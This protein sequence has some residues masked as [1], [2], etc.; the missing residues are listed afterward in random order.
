MPTSSLFRHTL[1]RVVVALLAF[2]VLV[3]I[4]A[5]W[6]L[7]LP[8]LRAHA[9]RVAVDVQATLNEGAPLAQGFVR[10]VQP[11][12]DGGPSLLPFNL[13]F[14][15]ELQA[16]L[17]LPVA[18]RVVQDQP[19]HY[20]FTPG[21]RG[22]L[23]SPQ[24]WSFDQTVVVG[25]WPTE[26][27]MAW[28][29]AALLSGLLVSLWLAS[30]LTRPILQLRAQLRSLPNPV[31]SSAIKPVEIGV[32]LAELEAL[33]QDYLALH[34]RISQSLE[35]RTTL[36]LGLAH[37]LSAPVSRLTM[38]VELQAGCA[39]STRQAAMARDLTE[40]R[41][42]IEQFLG[43]AGCLGSGARQA[44]S[45][46]ELLTWLNRHYKTVAGVQL[47]SSPEEKTKPPVIGN[48]YAMERILVNL[49]DNAL[50][51]GG[52]KVAVKTICTD[53]ELSISVIDQGP[54]LPPRDIERL[55][56]PFERNG[57]SGGTGLG[58]ALSRLIAEQNGWTLTAHC[59]QPH[60]LM[61]HLH[62]PKFAP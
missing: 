38:A 44:C 60:G 25:A 22:E 32:H 47:P 42:I 40:M 29:L 1:T 34:A 19:G 30:N 7:M 5:F 41:N 49:I 58:L 12:T 35:D 24:T 26:A 3:G 10:H 39:G 13:V 21:V 52:G 8:V 18:V 14:G 16:V 20:W 15:H 17:G 2:E 27:L 6:L 55:F 46:P 56:R 59:V 54:G 62:I 48:R 61:M 36:L 53:T 51:H 45:H 33:Q 4:L 23:K 9:H 11:P 50:R 31:P 28:L 37:D 57:P 43:A